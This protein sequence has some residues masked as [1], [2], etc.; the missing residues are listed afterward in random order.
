M[1]RNILHLQIH[2]YVNLAIDTALGF[3]LAFFL[4]AL[5]LKEDDK[6][7]QSQPSPRFNSSSHHYRK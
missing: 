7:N 1:L 5:S 3:A 4:L 6:A 2:P